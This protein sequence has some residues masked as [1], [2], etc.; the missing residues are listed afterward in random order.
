MMEVLHP[1]TPQLNSCIALNLEKR[2]KSRFFEKPHDLEF[3][4]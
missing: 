2:L 1:V 4:R 3:N